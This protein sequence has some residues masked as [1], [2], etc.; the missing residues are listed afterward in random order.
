MNT[1]FVIVRGRF[2]LLN[3]MGVAGILSRL[4]VDAPLSTSRDARQLG[5][6]RLITANRASLY[7]VIEPPSNAVSRS[8]SSS[9]TETDECVVSSVFTQTTSPVARSSSAPCGWISRRKVS[10]DLPT[11]ETRT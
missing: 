1:L 9:G 3:R 11:R 7:D 10:E 2:E 8:L 4:R 5:F 6:L